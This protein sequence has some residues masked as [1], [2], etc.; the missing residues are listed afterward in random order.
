MPIPITDVVDIQITLENVPLAG[1]A[2]NTGLILGSTD[3]ANFPRLRFYSSLTSVAADYNSGTEEFKAAQSYFSQSPTPVAVAIG[4]RRPQ[5]AQV[6]TLTINSEVDGTKYEFSVDGITGTYTAIPSDTP[7]TVA[8][9]LAT[10]FNTNLAG[11]VEAGFYTCVAAGAVIT[12]TAQKPGLGFTILK[13]SGGALMTVATTT[14]NAGIAEDITAILNAGHTSDW[15]GL[16]I[17]NGDTDEPHQDADLLAASALIEALNPRHVLFSPQQDTNLV[18]TGVVFA[19][20][21]LRSPW[22]F[23]ANYDHYPAASL[24]GFYAAS[25]PGAVNS[26]LKTLPGVTPDDLT[27]VLKTNIV[28]QNGNFY[29][30]LLGNGEV[31]AVRDGRCPNAQWIDNL[32]GVDFI[33]NSMTVDVLNY[34]R[35]QP[36]VPYTDDGISAIAGII[37][38]W[39]KFGVNILL[40]TNDP[41]PT[42]QQT[43]AS[44]VSSTLKAQRKVDN[45][46]I[47]FTAFL[48]NAINTVKITGTV[49]F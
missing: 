16:T 47:T 5:T 43:P 41:K 29:S 39:L 14:P 28:N 22:I 32:V 6:S 10:N 1:E 45:T 37:M 21:Y 8:A 12:V 30:Q 26:N 36:K 27:S 49:S 31:D 15:Y 19:N 48:A 46:V 24:M 34:L 3:V 25:Q 4:S 33:A 13:I 44:Q 38:K 9:N 7:S 20:A 42:I 35:A 17:A 2:F 18:S 40:F 23:T 11:S